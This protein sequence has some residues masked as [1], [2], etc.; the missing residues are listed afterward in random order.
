MYRVIIHRP[1]SFEEKIGSKA[2]SEEVHVQSCK[3]GILGCLST[4]ATSA[5]C[6]VVLETHAL[7]KLHLPEVC[8]S[9]KVVEHAPDELCPRWSRDVQGD[10]LVKMLLVT[11]VLRR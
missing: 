9:C 4:E 10:P 6:C 11:P 3:I 2:V 1:V 5:R 7:N 8:T